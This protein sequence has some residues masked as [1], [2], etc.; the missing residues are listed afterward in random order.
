MALEKGHSGQQ[1]WPAPRGAPSWTAL[2]LLVSLVAAVV[3][4]VSVGA[5]VMRPRDCAGAGGALSGAGS[6]SAALGRRAGVALQLQQRGAAAANDTGYVG[7]KEHPACAFFRS[8]NVHVGDEHHWGPYD[9]CDMD[10]PGRWLARARAN[11]Y[12]CMEPGLNVCA[13]PPTMLYHQYLERLHPTEWAANLLSIRAFLMTQDLRVSRML[14]WVPDPAAVYDNRTAA[15]FDAWSDYVTLQ[16][17]DYDAEVAGTLWDGDA[18]FGNGTKVKEHMPHAGSYSDVVR[19][20]LLHKYGGFWM[21]N[22]AVLYNDVSH[23]LLTGYQFVMRW[24]NLHIMRYAAGSALSVRAMELARSMP[25]DHPRFKEEIIEK[26]C[27]PHGYYQLVPASYGFTDVFNGCLHRLLLRFNNTGPPGAVLYDLPLGWWDHDWKGC[28]KSRE[29]INDTHWFDVASSYL[30]MHNRYPGDLNLGPA[31][32]PSPLRRVIKIITDFAARCDRPACVPLG[33]TPLV[34]YDGINDTPPARTRRARRTR[35]L[36]GAA[37]RGGGGDVDGGG[38]DGEDGGD[39]VD[40]GGARGAAPGRRRRQ[41]EVAAAAAR[42][43]R[44]LA[45]AGV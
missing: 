16:R 32:P 22:D 14:L 33:G 17:F 37:G 24:M 41:A 27:K 30:A 45:E 15:F 34:A 31:D 28:F 44:R 13:H 42:V 9:L 35:A 36:A 11:C 38:G 7:L 40:G 18:F 21:D 20:L 26:R 6:S 43:R 12:S 10:V 5:H 3:V 19:I 25:I 8:G 29:A 2:L 1:Q 23:L 4:T 39:G